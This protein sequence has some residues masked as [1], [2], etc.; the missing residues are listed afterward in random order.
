M[1]KTEIKEREAHWLIRSQ[2]NRRIKKE[3]DAEKAEKLHIQIRNSEAV[4]EIE[5]ELPKAS[6]RRDKRVIWKKLADREARKVRQAVRIMRVQLA[7][8]ERK[9]KRLPSIAVYTIHC[10]EIGP[11]NDKEK[12]EWFLLTS[13][14][15]E[16]I[17]EALKVI[18]W[19]LCQWQIEIFFKILKCGCRIE[20]LQF[21]SFKNMSNC[22]ALYMIVSWRI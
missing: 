11:L 12:I 17:E 8:V 16:T 9:G 10:E 4:G 3:E 2:H 13:Y 18:G 14:P 21:N 7:P 6:G 5:F 19:Y 22:I 1:E 15:I 20:E